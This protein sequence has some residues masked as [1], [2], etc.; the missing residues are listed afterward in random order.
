M[1]RPQLISASCTPLIGDRRAR[2]WLGK[3]IDVLA[4]FATVFGT[5]MSLGLGASQI[6]EGFRAAGMIADPGLGVMLTVIG[7]LAIGYLASAMS[8]VARGV[9]I[10]PKF[11][12]WMAA[13][14]AVF[15]LVA[16]PTVA[17]LETMPMALGSYLDQL[18]EMTARSAASADGTAG[19]WLGGWTIFYWVWWMSWTPFAGMFLARI[20][21]GRTIREFVVGIA[22]AMLFAMFGEL[23]WTGVVSVFAM[24]L[25][26]TFF[27][28]SRFR[29][30]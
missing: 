27:G 15:V 11:N 28:S 22:E 24:V 1:G 16:G 18:F 5:A 26:A 3:L 13:A 9:Q 21:R 19:D 30:L 2:G 8:G 10:K 25:L 17:Q 14:I 23:P 29:V 4:I 12:M 7:V 6:E 20:S